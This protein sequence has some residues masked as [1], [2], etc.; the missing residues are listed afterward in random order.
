LRSCEVPAGTLLL[1]E[2]AAGDRLHIVLDVQM[3][4]IKALRTDAGRSP[5]LRGPGTFLR[6]MSLLSETHRS[7]ASV[8][9]NTAL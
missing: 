8:R 5:G 2:G 7:T 4:I 9:A 1:Q 6:G 3:E